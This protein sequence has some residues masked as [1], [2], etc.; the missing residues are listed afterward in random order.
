MLKIPPPPD[1]NLVKASKGRSR[2]DT[3]E[4][5]PVIDK[6]HRICDKLGR[7]LRDRAARNYGKAPYKGQPPGKPHPR[8]G[9]LKARIEDFESHAQHSGR[10]K[11][12]SI[13]K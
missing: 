1:L 3:D 12:G 2:D 9:R 4:H 13:K 11:P 6:Q 5:E 8:A 7:P 10:R